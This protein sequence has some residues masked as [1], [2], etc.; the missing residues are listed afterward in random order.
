MEVTSWIWV[1]SDSPN[2]GWSSHCTLDASPY[3]EPW[4]E[5]WVPYGNPRPSLALLGW[6]LFVHVLLHVAI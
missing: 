4:D 5:S 3:D 2:N 1:D 6:L